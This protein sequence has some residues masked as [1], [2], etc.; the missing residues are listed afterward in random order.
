MTSPADVGKR[1]LELA[2]EMAKDAEVR[3]DVV[4][5]RSGNVRFARNEITTSGDS[6]EL[7]ISLWMGIGKRHAV[8]STNQTD[9][10]SVRELAKRAVAMARLSPEDPESQPLLSPQKYESVPLSF[11][12]RVATMGPGD[13]AAIA[14]RAVAQADR[15]KVDVAGFF[16]RQAWERALFSS[17]GLAATHRETKA[18]YTLTART[19]DGTGSGWAGRAS[20][21][22]ADIDDVA[23]TK[24]AI[25]KGIRSAKPRGLPPGKYTVILEPAA[26][27]E[28]LDFMVGEMDAR[29]ADEG[30]SFFAG[31]TGEKTFPDVV[32]L[33][34]NPTN[35]E[36]PGC[37]FDGEGMALRPQRWI[38]RG[39]VQ[40]LYV[41]RFWAAKKKIA[42]TGGHEVFHLAGGQADSLDELVRA[43]K[44]GLLVTRFWYTRMLEPQTITLT[45]LTRDG[46]FLVEDG[47]VTAPVANF[48]Y[49]ESPITV[50]KNIDAMTRT[51]SRVPNEGSVWH[52]PALRAHDFTM[53]SSSAA[54]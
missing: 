22:I 14:A 26:I 34:S 33:T 27:A 31:K 45:G 47:K 18:T 23:L 11:D 6:G 25:D 54:V 50:L 46:L 48:R 49:N 36:T 9:E 37:P 5:G 30:R 20:H 35:P 2:Q 10:T 4:S 28:M 13:R 38:D 8:V 32:S 41:S 17:S 44:R 40:D 39:R 7:S 1:V 21:R 42:P 16:Q 43:T 53:A 51:T 15:E 24:T 19:S 29:S 12:A 52:V 3:V